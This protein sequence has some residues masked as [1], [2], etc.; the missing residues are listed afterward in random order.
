MTK[1]YAIGSYHSNSW[2]SSNPHSGVYET[3]IAKTL[4]NVNCGNPACNQGGTIIVENINI[5]E[6]TSRLKGED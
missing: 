2:K 6:P 5:G 4:D 3:E 1:I